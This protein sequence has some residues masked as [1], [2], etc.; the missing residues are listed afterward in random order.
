LTDSEIQKLGEFTN[1]HHN[2]CSIHAT[3]FKRLCHIKDIISLH[4]KKGKTKWET[5][6]NE[7]VGGWFQSLSNIKKCGTVLK[8]FTKKPKVSYINENM[9]SPF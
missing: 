1:D 3:Y 8:S 6:Q 5:V 4:T 7:F 2:N 9:T